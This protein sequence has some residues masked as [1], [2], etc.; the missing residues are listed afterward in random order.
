MNTTLDCCDEWYHESY[1]YTNNTT[2]RPTAPTYDGTKNNDDDDDDDGPDTA[3]VQAIGDA[4]VDYWST[5]KNLFKDLWNRI[6]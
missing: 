6:F 4:T 2:A 3:V 5:T 1:N